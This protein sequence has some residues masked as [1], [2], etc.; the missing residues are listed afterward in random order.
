MF[1]DKRGD[2][3]ERIVFLTSDS[4]PDLFDSE[5]TMNIHKLLVLLVLPL[6]LSA[7]AGMR[8]QGEGPVREV[9]KDMNPFH[10]LSLEGKGIVRFMQ[11]PK[12]SVTIRAEE[13]I[14]RIMKV[15]VENSELQISYKRIFS[16]SNIPEFI[17][18]LP[19]LRRIEI[20]GLARVSNEGTFTVDHLDM[21]ISGQAKCDLDIRGKIMDVRLGGNAVVNLRG[22]CESVHL[23]ITGMA[24][25]AAQ[26]LQVSRATVR[27]MGHGNVELYVEEYLDVELNGAGRVTYLG[28]P[29]LKTRINGAGSIHAAK[30]KAPAPGQSATS[31]PS[32]EEQRSGIS[33]TV[34]QPQ[35]QSE[36]ND[37]GSGNSK[38]ETAGA[39]Q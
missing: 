32:Q 7:C 4:D 38:E 29:E 5:V 37:N 34:V 8:V 39:S 2:T 17:V 12:H 31:E 22:Y 19:D 16:T 24:D 6:W 30:L 13:N 14:L 28:S 27:L 1:Q 3:T 35:P 10:T 9:S 11:G 21:N 25:V 36:R 20:D 18:T 23:V 15:K 33:E 26:S